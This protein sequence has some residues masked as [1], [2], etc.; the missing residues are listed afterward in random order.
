MKQWC[1]M[2]DRGEIPAQ[3][4]TFLNDQRQRDRLKTASDSTT[5]STAPMKECQQNCMTEVKQMGQ[6]EENLIEQN[7][8]SVDIQWQQSVRDSD[9]VYN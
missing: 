9:K 1:I 8:T 7:A 2:L 4:I 6:S 5:D 3:V